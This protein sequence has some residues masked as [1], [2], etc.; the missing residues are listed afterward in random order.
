MTPS[1]QTATASIDVI[2]TCHNYGRYLHRCLSSILE[3]TLQPAQIVVVDDASDDTTPEV[4]QQFPGVTYERVDFRNANR[5]RNRGFEMTDSEMVVFF[6]AD[7]EMAPHFLDRLYAA[8][9]NDPDADFAY[10][11]RINVLDGEASDVP[12]PPGHWRSRP[13]DASLLRRFNYID[14]A[15]LVRR[16]SFPGFD[17]ALAMYQDWDLW[18]TMASRGQTGR[19]VP[20]PLFS[21]RVHDQSL[22]HR[23]D[24]EPALW[25]LRLKYR[26]GAFGSLPVIRNSFTIF[27]ALRR[28]RRAF[29][30]VRNHFAGE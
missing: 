18:L 30:S 23:T 19:Y 21:Y 9:Q 1:T 3:Q 5:S 12:E 16:S 24:P 7:N 27:R 10:C 28:L 25:R 2:V 4:A 6:D 29:G 15:S 17:E 8:L 26:I 14:L 22:G 11:D 13:F 20:Q